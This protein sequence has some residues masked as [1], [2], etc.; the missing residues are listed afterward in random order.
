MLS[1]KQL[2]IMR[3][4]GRI[5]KKIFDRIKE[6]IAP[7]VSAKEIDDLSVKMCKDAGVLSA[8]T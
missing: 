3:K 5:H 4:N 2:E 7:G 6:V 8:F 1:E